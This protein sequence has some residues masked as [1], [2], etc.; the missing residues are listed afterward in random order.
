MNINLI[1]LPSIYKRLNPNLTSSHYYQFSLT[2]HEELNLPTDPCNEDRSYIYQACIKQ[3]LTKTIGCRSPWD[4]WSNKLMRQCKTIEEYTKLENLYNR[5][6]T[7]TLENI[8]LMTGCLKP[9]NYKKYTLLGDKQP[10]SFVSDNFY[11]AL[12]GV[13]NDTFVE[14][15][16]LV[17][18]WT[19]LVASNE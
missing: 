1:G 17:Y 2:E 9:C 7:S 4:K 14:T 12:L 13:S 18:T 5:L 6:E 11:I 3:Y 8:N 16:V 19:S 15:E 10:S